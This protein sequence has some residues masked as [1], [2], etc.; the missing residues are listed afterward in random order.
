MQLANCIYV[1]FV[2]RGNVCGLSVM[3]PHIA[4]SIVEEDGKVRRE[5]TIAVGS[6]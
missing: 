6:F 1:P 5:I 4:I 3:F 2:V